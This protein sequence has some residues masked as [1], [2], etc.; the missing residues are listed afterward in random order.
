MRFLHTADWHLGKL[1]GRR[2]MTE[3]QAY[4]LEA[5]F[6]LVHESRVDAVV[7]AGDI[8]DRSVPPAEAVKLF[9][10]VLTRL[11]LDVKVPVFFIAGNHDSAARLD[12][13]SRLFER[14]GVYLRGVIDA[15]VTPI[16]VPDPFGDVYISLIPF[17]D[18]PSVREAFGL[19]KTPSFDEAMGLVV[20]QARE[21]IPEGARSIAVAHAFL[22]GGLAS[23][24]ERPLSVGGTD[25]VSP[26]HFADYSY[27]ALGH[28]HRP[29]K[30]GG[31]TIRYSGSLLKY[32]FDEA[33]QKKGVLIVDMD[34]KGEVSVET[35][36]LTPKHDVRIVKGFMD[37]IRNGSDE[38]PLDDYVRVDLLDEVPVL[39]AYEKLSAIYPNL[40]GITRPNV[41]VGDS[42]GARREPRK[43]SEVA[44]FGDF[45]QEMAKEPLTEAQRKELISCIEEVRRE[46]RDDG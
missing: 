20:K 19:E 4:V 17:C 18:P 39:N 15:S 26:A 22:A 27:T 23:E 3:D 1:F 6:D 5:F 45:F 38:L 14:A 41:H 25:A 11:V 21:G 32:S 28:L 42:Q 12:F 7:I 43:E 30:A 13:G 35:V 24:S 10:E 34:E 40:L 9:N 8:Y 37:E 36:P 46:E 2:Y 44:L 31:E 29:Q 16:V 33:A